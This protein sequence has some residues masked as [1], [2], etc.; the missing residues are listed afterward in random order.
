[1]SGPPADVTSPTITD[2]SPRDGAA[3]V[4]PSA[5][6]T[7]TFS[8]AMDATTLT[9]TTFTLIKQ[10]TTTPVPAAV[11]YDEATK[12][13]I[14]D[15]SADLDAGVTYSAMV[16]GGSNGAKDLAGNPLATDKVWSFTVSV[17]PP[18]PLAQDTFTRTLTG[19]WGTGDIGGAWSV[20]AGNASNFAVNGS[21]GTI[22]TPT[23]SVEQVAQLGSVSVRDVD[24]RVETTFPTTV[25][26]NGNGKGLFS[27]LLL[28]RQTGG[29]HYRVG[30]YLT[31]AGKVLI[32]GQTNTGTSLFADVDTGLSFTAG[33]TIALRVQAE[34]ANPTTIRA[35]AWKAGTA[36]PSAWRV[37][38]T[39]TTTAL[40]AAG[41]LGIRTLNS[42]ATVTTLSYDNLRAERLSGA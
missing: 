12:T 33:D 26:A 14:L 20:L 3:D 38:T 18:Q 8:E 17:A 39:N 9:A 19:S 5:T 23:K 31:P 32:R 4:A 40:Q 16:K 25:T 27:F 10:G 6:A 15:P 30:L 42:S 13:A 34:G 37:T 29:A 22:V 2:V 35:K 21:K 11:T 28:R 24:Y 7:A 1:M 36:E 41:T